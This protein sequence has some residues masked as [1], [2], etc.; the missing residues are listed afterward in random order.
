MTTRTRTLML[1]IAALAVLALLGGCKDGGSAE[2]SV[3]APVEEIPDI[4]EVQ[5][6]K[7]APEFT[8]PLVAGGEASLSDYK[9]KIL[10]LDFWATWCVGCVKELPDY[11]QFYDGWDREKVAYLGMSLDGDASTVAA[12]MAA[13]SDLSLPMAVASEDVVDAFL[14]RRTLP[15]SRVID[16]N[17]M[18]RYEF[19]GP[20]SAKVQEAVRRLLA[21]ED[22]G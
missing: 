6:V 12:F 21:E 11:Q 1:M 13:H 17:G 18:I 14:P 10:V 15:S 7:A 20:G 9:G 22:S 16:G 2:G 3:E 19:S 5:P 4:Q 8:V